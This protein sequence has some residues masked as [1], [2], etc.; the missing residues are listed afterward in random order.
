MTNILIVEDQNN[1]MNFI[2]IGGTKRG[3][4]VLK[5]L[6]QKQYIPSIVFILEQEKHEDL[7]FSNDLTLLC[8]SNDINHYTRK[9]LIEEDYKL[10]SNFFWDFAIVCG[11]RTIIK[12]TINKNFKIGIFAAHDS[13]LPKYRGFAP[14]NWCMINGEKETGVTL[15]KIEEGDE[16]SGLIVQQ[17]KIQIFESDYAIDVYEKIIHSTANIILK[18]IRNFK[19]DSI[20]YIKQSDELSTYCCARKPNDGKLD[21]NQ[22]S[23]KVLNFI[24]ALAPPYPGSFITYENNKYII[25]KAKLGNRNN[26]N[27]IGRIIGRVIMIND[28]GI[29]VLCKTGTILIEEII[30]YNTKE[31]VMLNKIIKSIRTTFN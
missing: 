31:T 2:F 19:N 23:K 1:Y 10:I 29:E 26:Y 13:L 18:F 20:K 6:I 28:K 15:F 17:E 14:L 30:D 7:N 9:K 12:T 24:K 16:D 21:F 27:Y 22:D 8:N 11:W 4:I 5:K 25:T 3:F